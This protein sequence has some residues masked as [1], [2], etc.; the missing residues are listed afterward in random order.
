IMGKF[1]EHPAEAAASWA[2]IRGNEFAKA[3]LDMACW[4]LW[5]TARGEP[6]AAALGGTRATVVAGVSLGI[7]PTVAEL[8]EQVRAQVAAGYPRIK[9]KIA[10][11]WDVEPV[12]AVR[13]E[14]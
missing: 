14:F 1:W 5:T 10:P 7:E 3:G 12:R 9:L 8:V 6:L 13:A 11:G 4:A 2:K